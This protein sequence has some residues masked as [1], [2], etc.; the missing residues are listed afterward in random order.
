MV[1]TFCKFSKHFDGSNSKIT[2]SSCTCTGI[3]YTCMRYEL[4]HVSG[5]PV[6]QKDF[7]MT[8]LILIMRKKSK[9]LNGVPLV[10][11]Q[12]Q[13]SGTNRSIPCIN[14]LLIS[15]RW[16]LWCHGHMQQ[17]LSRKSCFEN[18]GSLLKKIFITISL[19]RGDL[20]KNKVME[21]TINRASYE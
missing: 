19:W 13:A 21:P 11:I 18:L 8:F 10:A 3:F 9:G 16:N 12:K 1:E 20:T 2:G 14:F 7:F 15:L 17:R 6:V 5:E 4:S